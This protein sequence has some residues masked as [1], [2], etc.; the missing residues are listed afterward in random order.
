M[1]QDVNPITCTQYPKAV[2]L[3]QYIMAVLYWFRFYLAAV[4][5]STTAR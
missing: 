3:V 5:N 4:E 2:R 1:S